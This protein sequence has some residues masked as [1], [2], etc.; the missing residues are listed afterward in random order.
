V[1]SKIHTWIRGENQGR[2]KGKMK[3]TKKEKSIGKYGSKKTTR[4]EEGTEAGQ[5]ILGNFLKNPTREKSHPEDGIR[6]GSLNKA[7]TGLGDQLLVGLVE[8]KKGSSWKVFY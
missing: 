5:S 6:V 3:I 1:K 7:S 2:I 8:G 4:V